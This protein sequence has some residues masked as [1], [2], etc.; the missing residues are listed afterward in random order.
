MFLYRKIF[1]LSGGSCPQQTMYLPQIGAAASSIKG[2]GG[3]KR[4][5]L[6]IVLMESLW[7]WV[8]ASNWWG[9]FT[10]VGCIRL[11]SCGRSWVQGNWQMFYKSF[12]GGLMEENLMDAE[13][14]CFERGKDLCTFRTS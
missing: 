7:I 11:K 13:G 14:E 9:I 5:F 4:A 1:T 12:E 6:G 10:I 2:F 8:V 3:R